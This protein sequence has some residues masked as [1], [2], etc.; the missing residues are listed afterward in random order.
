MKKKQLIKRTRDIPDELIRQQVEYGGLS[1][2]DYFLL[3]MQGDYLVCHWDHNGREFVSLDDDE[4]NNFAVAQYLLRHGVP[5]YQPGSV[6][7]KPEPLL[8]SA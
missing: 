4:A 2:K 6:V 5:V 1:V 8:D 3:A 7:P